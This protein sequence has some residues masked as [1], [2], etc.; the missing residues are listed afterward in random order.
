ME[1]PD[2]AK[3]RSVSADK[4]DRGSV[5]LAPAFS[6]EGISGPLRPTLSAH[7]YA[8]AN[9]LAEFTHAQLGYTLIVGQRAPGKRSKLATLARRIGTNVTSA[10]DA[11]S[12]PIPANVAN[13]NRRSVMVVRLPKPAELGELLE[14][15]LALNLPFAIETP[16][17]L[18]SG[19]SGFKVLRKVSASRV[20]MLEL[21]QP[22]LGMHVGRIW[23]CAKA[24]IV[25]IAAAIN[26]LRCIMGFLEETIATSRCRNLKQACSCIFHEL[27]AGMT[28]AFSTVADEQ[29]TPPHSRRLLGSH[30]EKLRNTANPETARVS[31]WSLTR[32]GFN[33][34]DVWPLGYRLRQRRE[35]FRLRRTAPCVCRGLAAPDTAVATG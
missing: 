27:S 19:C 11:L 31:C 28:P 32:D 4:Q 8:C 35:Y 13:A 26:R 23:S 15:R 2:T 33:W 22:S 14:G 18:M 20:R 1:L 6:C 34:D 29:S 5:T 16:H 21:G 25:V 3:L 12:Q 9:N 24:I 17:Y 7:A 10:R 30:P